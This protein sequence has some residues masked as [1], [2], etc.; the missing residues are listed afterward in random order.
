MHLV[1][2]GALLL[3][4]AAPLALFFR[5]VVRVIILSSL[6]IMQLVI[7]SA[8]GLD[9]RPTFSLIPFFVPWTSL[10]RV[11]SERARSVFSR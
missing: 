2:M 1:G 11:L 9:F 4:L 10:R 3:E 8:M 5:G 6:V 7:F